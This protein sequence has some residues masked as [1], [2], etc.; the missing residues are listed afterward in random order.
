M[1][2]S[3]LAE[4]API[5]I[6]KVRIEDGFWAPRLEINR[7][8]TLPA[9]YE[10]CRKTGRL[11]AWKLKWKPGDPDPPHLFWDSDVAKWLE[12]A[13][14]ALAARPD[15]ELERLATD[16]I[17]MIV[18]AQQP[19]G[20]LNVHFTVVEPEKRWTNLRDWHELYC[21]GHLM[22]AAVAWAEATGRGEFL[23]VMC[24]CADHIGETFGPGPDLKPGYPGHEEIELALVRLYRATGTERYLKL[25]EFF[26]NERGRQPHYFALEARE[27]GEESPSSSF[28]YWQA[29]APVRDQQTAEGHAVRAMYLYCGMADVAAETG[30]RPLFEAC[31]RLWRNVTRRRM[32]VTGGIG[33]ARRGERFTFDHDLPNETAY[34]E[35][36]AAIGLMFFAHRMLQLELDADYA[37]V[38]ERALYNG[39]LSGVSLDGRR[40]FYVNPL[41]V[42]P[43]ATACER[44][45]RGSGKV[46]RHEWFWCACCPPNIA[47]LLASLGRYACSVGEH[48]AAVHLYVTGTADLDVAG[49]Q[50]QLSVRTDYPWQGDVVIEVLPAAP[51]EFTLALRIPGWCREPALQVNGRRVALADAVSKGYALLRRRWRAGD[52]VE[53]NL[54]M[55]IQRIEAHPGVR[56]DCGRVA[57]QR[58]P[59]VYC[60]EEADN[61]PRLH[62]LM[63]PREA[64]LQARHEPDL[65]GGLTVITGTGRRR[66]P[67]SW[68]DELYRPAAS[69]AVDAPLK[70]VPYFAW[71][72]REPGEMLVWIREG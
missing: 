17:D 63:L 49:E 13:A 72:N 41:T 29:H 44:A 53:L 20:Y 69:Q 56:M 24:R 5:P 47:R 59:I 4:R 21:A 40:F 67:A 48:E 62:D 11:D 9:E 15:P 12:A 19:D 6:G 70:A 34:A 42:Y 16:V 14:C 60:L 38:M 18:A 2:Q 66:D 65:L 25:A 39:V 23:E 31:R 46:E 30:D 26:I 64:E 61:G 1:P 43:D 32:Y 55:A 10:Q 36:C 52:R 33:S 57:L 51:L 45:N 35:T 22:E 71:C 58:G 3:R 68:G 8:V 37:D 54:P 28:D 27:R 50:V 7:T